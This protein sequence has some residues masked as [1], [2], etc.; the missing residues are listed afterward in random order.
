M[1]SRLP[2]HER[3]ARLADSGSLLEIGAKARS[4]QP[5]VS[6]VT[7]ADG[8]HIAFARIHDQEV[9]IAAENQ[10]V[11]KRSDREVARSKLTRALDF[12]LARSLPMI[13]VLDA[14]E[15]E[16]A[17]FEPTAGE[18][19]GRM[20]DPSISPDPSLRTAPL[21]VIALGSVRG[22]ASEWRAH[23]DLVI[24]TS[25]FENTADLIAAD[26]SE[27]LEFAR[28]AL[29][30]LH[31]RVE[32]TAD[33]EQISALP[34]GPMPVA[35]AIERLADPGASLQLA[36]GDAVSGR[37]AR[38]DGW[39]TL[40]LGAQGALSSR[41]LKRIRRGVD[42]SGRIQVPLVLLQDCPGYDASAVADLD[43]SARL[44]ASY[45]R[46]S[47]PRVAVV[48]GTGHVLGSFALG[49]RPLGLDFAIAWPWAH[50]AVNDP[51]AYDVDSLKRE[52]RP[53]P[54]LAAGLGL[55][56]DVLTPD[57]TAQTLRRLVAMFRH[58][59]R[60]GDASPPS[61]PYRIYPR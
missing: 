17:R 51:P 55:V 21:L 11:L 49:A 5:S 9:L 43:A 27:A 56:E 48:C 14:P 7:P 28:R 61:D 16:L 47:N 12:A 42:L 26:D 6:E 58:A 18:L 36:P 46:W 44:S 8:L 13:L 3:L 33:D 23:A 20:A 52:R 1:N 2:T 53:D 60:E 41:D 24:T 10:E 22:L 35:E 50:L 34:A 32:P 31:P 4:Q 45:R 29:A 19:H 54:W 59:D 30:W 15:G 39:P 57:E 25:E 38:I 37:L 40:F